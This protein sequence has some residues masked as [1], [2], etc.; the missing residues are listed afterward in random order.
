METIAIVVP[1]C[2]VLVALISCLLAY[3]GYKRNKKKDDKEQHEKE[4]RLED[5]FEYIKEKLDE[6]VKDE[7]ETKAEILDLRQRVTV[8]E[9][10]TKSAH[11]RIDEII[12]KA[13]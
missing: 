13:S 6:L 12:A 7:K 4:V 5:N 3:F 10:S 2:S 8:V 1:I 11:K 9:E